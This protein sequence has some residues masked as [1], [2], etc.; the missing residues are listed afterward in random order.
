MQILFSIRRL[1]LFLSIKYQSKNLFKLKFKSNYMSVYAFSNN[2]IVLC[3]H[4][5]RVYYLA[6]FYS[7]HRRGQLAV[8]VLLEV[9]IFFASQDHAISFHDNP[10]YNRAYASFYAKNS[11]I[12]LMLLI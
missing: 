7:T 2:E 6:I 4:I 1:L 5:S 10:Q 12:Y 11:L 9:K 3:M 8:F